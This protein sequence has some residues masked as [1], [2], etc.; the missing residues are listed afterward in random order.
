MRLNRAGPEPGREERG[1]NESSTSL[2]RNK[3]ECLQSPWCILPPLK[4]CSGAGW[5]ICLLRSCA[6][7]QE[8]LFTQQHLSWCF[9]LPCKNPSSMEGSQCISP[10]FLHALYQ[11]VHRLSFVS[12]EGWWNQTWCQQSGILLKRSKNQGKKKNPTIKQDRACFCTKLVNSLTILHKSSS[13]IVNLKAT[14]FCPAEYVWPSSSVLQHFWVLYIVQKI[15][16]IFL[17]PTITAKG[18]SSPLCHS[19]ISSASLRLQECLMREFN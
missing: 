2:K 3:C 12:S 9:S 5:I 15:S 6:E 18:I 14:S 16:E 17:L 10:V 4:T 11:R 13:F 19:L 7:W 1:G 8:S